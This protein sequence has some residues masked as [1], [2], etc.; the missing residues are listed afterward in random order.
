MHRVQMSK[1][2][3]MSLKNFKKLRASTLIE[4]IIALTICAACLSIAILIFVQIT[5]SSQSITLIRAEQQLSRMLFK[6]WLEGTPIEN[7]KESFS[8]FSIDKTIEKT[9]DNATFIIL[10]Y[11]AQAQNREVSR[12]LLFKKSGI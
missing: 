1:A 6:D 3:M 11:N 9:E 5:K 2:H 8:A 4:S 7:T 10:N 12:R